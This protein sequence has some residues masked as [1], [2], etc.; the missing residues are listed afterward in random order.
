AGPG[1]GPLA[2]GEESGPGRMLEPTEITEHAGRLL[3]APQSRLDGLR[4]LITSGPTREPL[5]PVRYVGN[6]SSGKTGHALAAAAWRRGARVTLVTGPVP[7]DS[8]VGAEVVEV[9]TAREMKEAVERHIGDADV[10]VFAAAVADYRPA[11]PAGQKLKRSAAGPELT[12]TLT[13]N[14]DVAGDTRQARRDGA[15]VVGFAL[16]TQDLVENARTK[17][18]AKGFDLIVANPADEKGAG[19]ESDTNRVTLLSL[20]G[21]P[22]PLP[23]QTKDALAEEI[24][25][26]VE[27]MLDARP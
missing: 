4:V 16:E 3:A 17:L 2:A 10:V 9:E 8:P 23:V 6:R 22:E 7:T 26:R 18:E 11:D 24:L 27:A 13:A 12:L 14:P 25:D 20:G 19:F 5:D 21:D 1:T 15:V